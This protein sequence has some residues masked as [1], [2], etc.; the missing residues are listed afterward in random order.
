MAGG[1]SQ[2]NQ[3]TDLQSMAAPRYGCPPR[4]S[5]DCN[6]DQETFLLAQSAEGRADFVQTLYSVWTLQSR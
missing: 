1:G 5:E 4:G 2:N 3:I 6:L